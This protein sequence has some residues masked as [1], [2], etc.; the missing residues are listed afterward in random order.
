MKLQSVKPVPYKLLIFTCYGGCATGVAASKACVRI[1]EENPDDV[2][3]G[4]LPAVIVPW[5]LNEIIKNSE[6]RILIDACGVRCGAK[7]V[8]REGM[9]VDHYIELTSMLGIRKAKRLPSKDLEDEVYRTIRREVDGLLGEKLAKAETKPSGKGTESE[10]FPEMQLRPVGVVKNGIKEPSLVAEAGDLEWR[11]N[12]EK[13][14]EERN[15]ISELVI[16]GDLAAIL[17]GIEDFSHLL[18][19][20]WAHRVPREGRSLI[21]GHPIGRKDLPLVGIFATRSPAR[22]NPICITTVPLLERKG[23]VLKVKGLDAV[24]GSPL[25]D[26]KPYNPNYDAAHEVKLAE[27]M[28]QIHR[29]IAEGSFLRTHGEGIQQT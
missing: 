21:K 6:K 28:T 7:L 20:Y 17:D 26:I 12:L 2:K 27:W 19:L 13:A 24:D 15:A 22:P 10:G 1:W 9:P 5:K 4:C 18:V 16:E 11:A 14:R 23:N 3:I 8:E 25:L 29:E